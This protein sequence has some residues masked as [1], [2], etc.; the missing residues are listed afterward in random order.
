MN[1]TLLNTNHEYTEDFKMVQVAN[2]PEVQINFVR[3]K[4]GKS[5]PAH[6]ANS[7]VRLLG[8][9]GEI[10]IEIEAGPVQIGTHEIA[11]VAFGTHMQIKNTQAQDAAFLV[12]KAP[13]P[14]EM[15]GT[16]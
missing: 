11:E 4:A 1:K 16:A 9:E 6:N 15:K 8:L 2:A 3:V 12:I 13:N 14:S 7:N 5:L 10:T